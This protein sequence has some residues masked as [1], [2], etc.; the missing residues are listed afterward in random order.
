MLP[1]YGNRDSDLPCSRIF[2]DKS[3]CFQQACLY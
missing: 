2:K 1:E 3:R